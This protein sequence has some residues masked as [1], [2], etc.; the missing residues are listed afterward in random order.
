MSKERSFLKSQW[1]SFSTVV[2]EPRVSSA[3]YSSNSLSALGLTF[4]DTPEVLAPLD[5]SAISCG[6]VFGGADDGKGHGVHEHLGVLSRSLVV[7]FHRWSVGVNGLDLNSL[8]DLTQVLAGSLG[9]TRRLVTYSLLEDV[10]VL[11]GHGVGL[12]NDRNE[13]DSGAETL[14]DFNVQRLEA[15]KSMSVSQTHFSCCCKRGKQGKGADL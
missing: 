2:N 4:R 15:G 14:H 13:V 6:H 12:G 7:G 11:G 10:Q 3:S 5:C 9:F 8:T 1:S